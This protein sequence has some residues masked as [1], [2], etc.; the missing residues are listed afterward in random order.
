MDTAA[1]LEDL[2]EALRKM[3]IILSPDARHSCC[4]RDAAAITIATDALGLDPPWLLDARPSAP[5]RT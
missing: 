4:D 5:V 2:E 1:R 3:V